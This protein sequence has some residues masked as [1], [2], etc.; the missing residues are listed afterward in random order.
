MSGDAKVRAMPRIDGETLRAWRRSRGWDVPEMARRLRRAA[1]DEHMPAHDSLIRQIR[2]WERPGTHELSE[3][4]E[5]LYRRIGLR[6]TS[7]GSLVTGAP[8][9]T[10]YPRGQDGQPVR[11]RTLAGLTGISAI[12]ALLPAPRAAQPHAGAEKLA[13]M[14]TTQTP[15]ADHEPPDLRVLTVQVRRARRQYQACQYAELL[16]L[17]PGLLTELTASCSA[18][19]GDARLGAQALSADAYHVTAGFLLKRGDLG[20]AHLATDRSMKAAVASQDPLA[21]GASARIVTHTLM[22]SGHL[23]AAVTTAAGHSARLSREIPSPTPESLSVYGS[24]LLRGAIAAALDGE[25]GT[26]GEMLAEAAAAAREL[27]A[28]SNL[29]G[30]AFSPVNTALHQVNVAVTLGDAGT[31]IDLARQVDIGQVTVTER[32]ASLLIDTARAFFMWGRYEHAYMSLRAAEAAA[33][34]EVSTRPQVSALARDIAILAP[35][36]IKRDTEQFADRIGAL[37]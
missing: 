29:C 26:A 23:K 13:L 16:S 7:A 10:L 19:D 8:V 30:T 33:P 34:Q 14:L 20:L 12:D 9:A 21:V 11:K 24:I 31:A 37:I 6:D 5:L 28:D 17:L 25:R 3:R 32:K 22:N 18:L 35:P 4:Y 27:A 36:S 15:G 2:R 1:G